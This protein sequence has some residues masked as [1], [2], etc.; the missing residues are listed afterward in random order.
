MTVTFEGSTWVEVS[1]AGRTQTAEKNF[2]RRP[3]SDK[4][5]QLLEFR[6]RQMISNK[7]AKHDRKKTEMNITEGKKNLREVSITRYK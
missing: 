7:A 2:W 4:T 6:L 3:K 5:M 1:G